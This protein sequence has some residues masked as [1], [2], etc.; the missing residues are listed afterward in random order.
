MP[1]PFPTRI[2][3]SK[4]HLGGAEAERVLAA[5]QSN[6]VSTCGPQLDEL[7]AEFSRMLGVSAL[8]LSSG[9]AAIHVGLRLLGVGPGDEVVCPALTFVGTASPACHLQAKPVFLDVDRES[10]GLDAGLLT[11]FLDRRAR[12]GRLPRAVAVVHLFGQVANLGEI[13]P[14][15]ARHGVPVLEDAA[16]ALGAT[17][18][19]RPVG[20]FGHL[21]VFS[22]NGNKIVTGSAGGLLCS[23]NEAWI[24]L[25]RSWIG[26]AREPGRGY[27]HK[28][29]GYNYRLSNIAA[30]LLL[31]QLETLEERLLARRRVAGRYAEG[32]AGVPG[33]RLKPQPP[34]GSGNHWLSCVLVEEGEYGRGA[35]ELIEHLDAHNVDA[36]PVWKPLHTQPVFKGCESVAG[37]VAED[38]HRRGI[39]LPSSTHLTREEQDFVMDLIRGFARG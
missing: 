31:G 32:L 39:C 28:E 11:G 21:G 33:V 35:G 38:L 24:G 27:L 37:G 19:G 4:P 25:A 22:F 12:L 17:F 23:A 10:W 15:C 13:I 36:R 20:T 9:T 3:L 34:W 14:A 29:L 8:A 5:L 26:H 1:S 30:A 7:E 2:H 18:E 6:W 16:G